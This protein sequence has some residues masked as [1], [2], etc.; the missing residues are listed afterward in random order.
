MAATGRS[1][2]VNVA[3]VEDV[4]HSESGTVIRK[5]GGDSLMV[6]E[7]YLTVIARLEGRED[8]GHPPA[9]AWSA[10]KRQ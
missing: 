6:C 7:P 4:W 10:E 3:C 2:A 8:P 5:I 1:H 9:D